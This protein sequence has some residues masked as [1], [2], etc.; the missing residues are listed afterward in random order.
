M[1]DHKVISVKFYFFI[2]I[3]LLAL[4]ALAAFTASMHF[5]SL[6]VPIAMIISIAKMTLII[7]YFMHV[8]YGEPLVALTIIASFVFLMILFALTLNDY[9]TRYFD[10]AI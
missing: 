3:I 7:L 8:R 1:S 6:S 2:Y 9:F 10:W 5:G 4:T